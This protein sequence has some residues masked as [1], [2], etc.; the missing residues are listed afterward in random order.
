MCFWLG[1]YFSHLTKVAVKVANFPT[2]PCLIFDEASSWCTWAWQK[3]GGHGCRNPV[4]V[5]PV[6]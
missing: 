4:G 6:C 2:P 1:L 3:L 5:K